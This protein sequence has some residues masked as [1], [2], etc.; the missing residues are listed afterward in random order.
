MGNCIAVN[1]SKSNKN[2]EKM[3]KIITKERAK[4]MLDNLYR[5]NQFLETCT[6]DMFA[7][8]QKDQSIIEQQLYVDQA[9]RIYDKYC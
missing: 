8:Y 4:E 3:A 2:H 5:S 6:E 1:D 7:D 9:I